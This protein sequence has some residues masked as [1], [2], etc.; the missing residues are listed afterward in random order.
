MLG[1]YSVVEPSLN[2]LM[3]IEDCLS[4]SEMTKFT[5][6][7]DKKWA[8]FTSTV[9]NVMSRQKMC[10]VKTALVL[11]MAVS[12]KIVFFL[13]RFWYWNY[14]RETND[15]PVKLKISSKSYQSFLK[16][17]D[18]GCFHKQPTHPGIG[19]LSLNTPIIFCCPSIKI[20]S[21]NLCIDFTDLIF[22][23]NWLDG[24]YNETPSSSSPECI[25]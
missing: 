5:Y 6:Q 2:V 8:V 12:P 17:L 7:V 20:I 11:T 19:F 21:S 13:L 16:I 24:V 22:M 3:R 4:T 18:F 25:L 10:V 14:R 23:K 1:I 15:F 9:V